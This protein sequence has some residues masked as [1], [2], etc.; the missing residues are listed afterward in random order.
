MAIMNPTSPTRFVMKAFLPA[1]AAD[2]RVCQKETRKYEQTPT[3]SQPRKVT[4]R[5]EP[6]TR[7]SIEKTKRFR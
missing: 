2:G 6:S 7:I 1:V 3:P 4:T 5:F